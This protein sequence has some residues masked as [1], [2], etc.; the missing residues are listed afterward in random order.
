MDR[1]AWWTTV[2]GVAKSVAG[3]SSWG[4]KK[5]DTTERLTLKL[6]I[7]ASSLRGLSRREFSID[8]GQR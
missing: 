3:Y 8:L 7:H 6:E 5:L 2:Q 1:G 4:P